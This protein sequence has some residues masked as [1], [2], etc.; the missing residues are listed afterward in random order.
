MTVQRTTRSTI[1]VFVLPSD[2]LGGSERVL[3]MLAGEAARRHQVHVIFCSGGDHGCWRNAAAGLRPHFLAAK[4]YRLGMI[5][6]AFVLGRLS[7]QHRI[8]SAIASQALINGV[9]GF[10]RRVRILR[11]RRL[12]LRESTVLGDRFSGI[13]WSLIRLLYAIGYGAADLVICQTDYM[14]RKLLVRHPRSRT[15]PLVVRPNPLDAAE[16]VRL[17]SVPAPGDLASYEPYIVSVG[18]LIAIKGFDVLIRAFAALAGRHTE[19]KLLILGE[20]P[21]RRELERLIASCSL[22]GRVLLP[23]HR[24]NP[25]PYMAHARVG[26]VASRLE[27]FPNVLLEL[28]ATC[29]SVVSTRCA[30]G[31]DEL[32]GV[33]HCAPDDVSGLSRAIE[34][35]LTTNTDTRDMH[36]ELLRSRSPAAFWASLAEDPR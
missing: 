19:V 3:R 28:M 31:I 20:G 10:L 2:A 21:M 33:L 6:A 5:A 30:G 12:I 22:N 25:Y 8:D 34:R 18:R 27:G 14:R 24:D 15:W 26:I 1:S 13:R 4:N 9:L 29:R 35:A 36:R 32:P 23:G 17:A 7:R 16:V 11:C